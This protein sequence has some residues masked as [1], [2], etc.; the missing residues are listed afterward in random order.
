MRQSERDA[1]FVPTEFHVTTVEDEKGAFGILSI[2]TTGGL[3]DL[4]LDREAADALV[5]A[6]SRLHEELDENQ[7]STGAGA[8]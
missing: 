4:A 1:P 6:I 3:L 7:G 5:E 8:S 2:R